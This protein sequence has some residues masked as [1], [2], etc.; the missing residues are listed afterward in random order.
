[1][2]IAFLLISL[3]PFA[4][5]L[6]VV[7]RNIHIE[8]LPLTLSSELKSNFEN[9]WLTELF[10]I[11]SNGE[12]AYFATLESATHITILKSEGTT[13]WSTFKKEKRK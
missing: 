4:K 11:S 10:E 12:T 6:I 2:L 9:S 7:T 1:M 8:Q 5:E 3:F 13:G